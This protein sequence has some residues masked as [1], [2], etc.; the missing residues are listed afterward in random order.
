MAILA[1]RFLRIA[2]LLVAL[3]VCRPASA[4]PMGNF[5][6]NHY[7]RITLETDRIRVCY[8]ID[9][10]EI[11]TYQELQRA[12]IPTNTIDPNSPT[13]TDYVAARSVEL[14]KGL[15]LNVD[16]KA[17]LLRLVSS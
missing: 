5:S 3:A 7:T 9:L 13:V 17:V 16:G 8:L 12:N 15:I 10:A 1:K 14:G 2:F 4:H 6:V 11:P